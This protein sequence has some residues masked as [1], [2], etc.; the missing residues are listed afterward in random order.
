MCGVHF[1]CYDYPEGSHL[2]EY[3]LS[4]GA[5]LQK[6]A[7]YRFCNLVSTKP[8]GVSGEV[9]VEGHLF[10]LVNIFT[11]C[12]C[13]MCRKPL[14]GLSAQ[15]LKC[16]RCNL[17]AHCSC[18]RRHADV[19]IPHCQSMTMDATHVSLGWMDLR[20]SFK[21]HYQQVLTLLNNRARLTYEELSILHS[22][23]WTQLQI[24]NNGLILGSVVVKRRNGTAIIASMKENELDEFEIHTA[25]RSVESLLSSNTPT[26][27]P[28]L[29]EYFLSNRISSAEHSIFYDW[30]TL[31]YIT[32]VLKASDDTWPSPTASFGLLSV[33]GPEAENELKTSFQTTSMGRIRDALGRGLSVYSDDVARIFLCHMYESGLFERADRTEHL[34]NN[35]EDPALIECSFA[36]P[37]GLDESADVEHI[38]ASVESCLCDLDL[39]VNEA[40]FLL[41]VRRLWPNEM[42]SDYARVRLCG[43]IITW[44]LA[45]DENLASI[46]RDYV[47]RG[48]PL[49]GVRSRLEGRSWPSP[50][51]PRHTPQSSTN[52]GGD[53]VACRRALLHQYATGWLLALHN[54]DMNAYA[55]V[56]YD[57]CAEFAH[58]NS[59]EDIMTQDRA[60][61]DR[62]GELAH[63]DDCLRLIIKLAQASVTFAIPEDLI[64]LWLQHVPAECRPTKPLPTIL[65]LFNRE[66]DGTH[67]YSSVA[68]PS[69]LANSA[70]TGL[71]PWSIVMGVAKQKDQFRQ[72][73]HWLSF[74]A[75]AG[76]DVPVHV[77]SQFS[78]FVSQYTASLEDSVTLA[79]AALESTWLKSLGHQRLQGMIVDLH[80]LLAKGLIQR[81]RT[82]T[83]M[84]LVCSFIRYS[85]SVCLLLFGCERKSL[86]S[87]GLVKDEEVR[88]LPSRRKL[89]A[90]ASAMVDPIIV[91]ARLI[92]CL[93][94][95][96]ECA[97]E[98]VS[99]I[100]AKFL[101]MLVKEAALLESYEVDNFILKNEE[102]LC[103][104]AWK[105]Y[106]LQSHDIANARTSFLLR[107]LVVDTQPFRAI[108]QHVFEESGNWESRFQAVACL[109]RM[110]LDVTSPSFMVEDRQFRS[111]FIDVF[112]YYFRALWAD[113]KE[114]IRLTVDTWSKTL[115]PVHFDAIAT[116]WN[117][118]LPKIPVGQRVELIAFLVQLRPHFP[119]W[120]VLSWDVIVEMI[121]EDDYLQ[122]NGNNEDGPASAHL[123][124]YGLSS[125]DSTFINADTDPDMSLVRVAIVIL[126][127]QM[128]ANGIAV[129]IAALLRIKTQLLKILG[130]ADVS[131]IPALSG[132]A[133][134][135][136]FGDFIEIPESALPCISELPALF[137]AFH[138]FD[139]A[140]S[141]MGGPYS[142]EET[143]AN[144]LVG[145]AFVDV[146]LALVVKQDFSNMPVG[147]ARHLMEALL[148]VIYKHDF[149][150]RPLRHLMPDLRHAVRHVMD[151]L[152]MDV[153]YELRRLSVS[154]CNAYIKCW[155]VTS[156]HI[157]VDS[158]EIAAKAIELLNHNG[159]DALV[160]QIRSFIETTLT[161]RARGGIFNALCKQP[162]DTNFLR[163]L[164]DITDANA[165]T[166]R[167][168]ET[169][170]EV[171]LFDTLGRAHE[172]DRRHLQV[173]VN[174]LNR[175]VEIV[176][177]ED[178][179]SEL[180]YQVGQ[181]LGNITRRLAEAPD[182]YDP[183]PMFLLAATLIEHN[184]ARSHVSLLTRLASR[185]GDANG[186]IGSILGTL[187]DGLRGRG[188]VTPQT[189]TS[190]LEILSLAD[191]FDGR[192]GRSLFSDYIMGI[193]EDAL[194]YLSSSPA[195]TVYSDA[196]FA[197]ARAAA[198]MIM[199]T[200][201]DN[202]EP[203]LKQVTAP[204]DKT[205]R[206]PLSIR[207]WNVLLVTALCTDL[208]A[209]SR[210]LL[211]NFPTF[212]V[213]YHRCLKSYHIAE[214]GTIGLT[215][216]DVNYAYI[217]IKLWLL[218]AHRVSSIREETGAA[219]SNKEDATS[220][221]LWND[222]WPPFE[223]LLAA[224]EEDA[225][226]G[227][228]PATGALILSS[229]ADL[230][231]FLHQS[232]SVVMLDTALNVEVLTRARALAKNETLANKLSRVLRTM[233]EPAED[234]STEALVKQVVAD[235]VATEK[236]QALEVRRRDAGKAAYEKKPERR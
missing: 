37:F 136:R 232:R 82:C 69:V 50:H 193:A 184:R 179:T 233:S 86:L 92:N 130:F 198:R 107:V 19:A 205:G 66:G 54:L 149:D 134:H 178:C 222:L 56:I 216:A 177:H 131:L 8:E 94:G 47:A 139:L 31:T 235:L 125:R 186:I 147:T 16:A 153:A 156:T 143:P 152:L 59:P 85:L 21:D 128:I 220:R 180:M 1:D 29:Q 113:E 161:M 24:M 89:N 132:H 110:I 203:F 197:C 167:N 38:V 191:A 40:G 109:F 116:C 194:H 17:F 115:L 81:M 151:V 224:F 137:D 108:L 164:R 97:V 158:I 79:Q 6:V 173:V 117:E 91:D 70:L 10:G 84:P 57:I 27:S 135:V 48:R 28:A 60:A 13:F 3:T 78:S 58:D 122:K 206:Q 52:N 230:F 214:P 23:F 22:T 236:L 123:S 111:S 157:L 30:P 133:F 181:F 120:Q 227:S 5:N 127:L 148:I 196:G 12:L 34:F 43:S 42:T 65:R 112:H 45:E 166:V 160:I 174:N 207:S 211:D 26:P 80:S 18:I 145:S 212:L 105:F 41:L 182:A 195:S 219:S 187:S 170:R 209:S 51:D 201:E 2:S 176:H 103:L 39:S 83:S 202:A 9:S 171:L 95:Y 231:M 141:A 100:I 101:D 228:I 229:I 234:I 67:R 162:L 226:L 199:E 172:N 76:V 159:E 142:H 217:S 185:L 55:C 210:L 223:H 36:L 138:P 208:K 7:V 183:S 215:G 200:T 46:L 77:Y 61:T 126:S 144:L 163:V 53:Y 119:E 102:A 25:A 33:A 87:C 68:D 165:K 90:R 168:E 121:L 104:C 129:D 32:S 74:L 99:I 154:I 190:I 189:L 96:V 15:G 93:R 14:W 140:P 192:S 62:G 114:E 213:M 72:S 98:E 71:D 49:P 225:Q 118:A 11:L 63:H 106:E 155:G 35:G 75:A 44:I 169:L 150:S 221:M 64:L 218:L 88:H 204:S 73:L 188:R 20:D 146:L 124:M 4:E 175:Y